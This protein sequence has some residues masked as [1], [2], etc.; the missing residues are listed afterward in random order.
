[1][2]RFPGI[3]LAALL[4]SAA[5]LLL[6]AGTVLLGTVASPEDEPSTLAE[7]AGI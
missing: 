4:A 2:K 1:M 6:I 5:L 3:A 7:M